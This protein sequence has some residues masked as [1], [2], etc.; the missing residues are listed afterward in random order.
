MTATADYQIR[1]ATPRDD[2][3]I[4]RLLCATLGWE[5]DERHRALFSWKHR[6]NPFGASFGWVAEDTEG[7]IGSRTFMRWS[8]KHQGRPVSAVR[9]VDTA[10]HP[11]AQGRGV[12]RALTTHGVREM[13]EAGVDWVFNTPN[14]RSAPGYLS[15]GWQQMG[16][17][18][19]RARPGPPWRWRRL[20][21]ARQ[22]GD[23]WSAST[24][25]GEAA[26][27]VL[28]DTAGLQQL[29]DAF[30]DETRLRTARSV[31]FLRWRYTAGPIDYRVVLAGQRVGEG[32]VLFRHRRR[33]SATEA[34]V[35]DIIGPSEAMRVAHQ[36]LG[37]ADYAVTLGP[38]HPRWWLRVP[39]TGPV[40]TWRALASTIPPEP[41]EWELN[42]G[43]IELF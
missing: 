5:D 4:V 1:P 17:V 12:F 42:A 41:Q 32:I 27:D 15:M 36:C 31:D 19:A 16:Q 22:P 14:H 13:T 34:V 43:D 24:T 2:P 30:G 6:A 8:F 25:A 37:R 39:R 38:S 35:T 29:L 3:A 9:A 23:L 18:T 7:L 10:T 28:D 33:G 20:V 26:T 21:S 40:L 11:R